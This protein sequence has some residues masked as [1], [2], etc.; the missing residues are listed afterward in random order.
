MVKEKDA[1][2]EKQKE[3]WAA[4]KALLACL[5]FPIMLTAQHRPHFWLK[6]GFST[7]LAIYAGFTRHERDV[8][9]EKYRAYQA[10]WP[11]ANPQWSNPQLSRYNKYKNGDVAQGRAK[12]FGSINKPVF[13]TDK[14]HLSTTLTRTAYSGIIS[15]QIG[16]YEKPTLKQIGRQVL[17]IFAADCVG[18]GLSTLLY[19]Y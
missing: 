19:K 7:G 18:N 13:M 15:L 17:I 1:P 10:V 12:L 3:H 5:I 6:Q 2:T 11:K 16:L 8:I 9:R 14:Y 4:V